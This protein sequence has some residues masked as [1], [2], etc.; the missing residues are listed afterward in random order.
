LGWVACL[1]IFLAWVIR[2]T[3]PPSVKVS[4][5]S[6]LR[7]DY[8]ADPRGWYFPSLDVDIIFD[9]LQGQD[10]DTAP[11]GYATLVSM[12]LTPVATVTPNG[13]TT[14]WIMPSPT[15]GITP[16]PT[17]ILS[18]TP[19]FTYTPSPTASGTPI[20]GTP[21]LTLTLTEYPGEL[22]STPQRSLTPT[23]RASATQTLR[24]IHTQT[25]EPATP[26]EPPTRT[27]TRT[28]PPDPT[29]TSRP[30]NTRNPYPYP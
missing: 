26:T 1:T 2:V 13:T 6:I 24:P 30:T 4:L 3:I 17:P 5:S 22:T 8:S 14:P 28:R 9:V 20:M 15:S 16:T 25:A 18:V 21:E 23:R 27:A 7:A 11:G 29:Q 10:P 19:S 12:Q